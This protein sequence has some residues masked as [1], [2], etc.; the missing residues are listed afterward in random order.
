MNYSLAVALIAN[1]VRLAIS[2]VCSYNVSYAVVCC[3]IRRNLRYTMIF[4]VLQQTRYRF[5]SA[6][7]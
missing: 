1:D 7:Y 5:L 4:S 6:P 2:I 3:C